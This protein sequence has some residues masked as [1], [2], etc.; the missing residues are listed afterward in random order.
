M[1]DTDVGEGL[2]SFETVKPGSATP[3]EPPDLQDATPQA[4]TEITLEPATGGGGKA[5]GLMHGDFTSIGNQG[6]GSVRLMYA[7]TNGGRGGV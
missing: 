5:T 6:L 2:R 1:K 3:P 4:E 7:C